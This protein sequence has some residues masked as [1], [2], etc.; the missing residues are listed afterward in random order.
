MGARPT[1]VLLPGH[2]CTEALWS[3]QCDALSDI[4]D[5]LPLPLLG[6]D[7]MQG[8][9][10]SVLDS[11]PARFSLA[12]LS[13][14]GH[15]AM[16]IMRLAPERVER[17]ALID[18]R[19]DVDSPERLKLRE[20]DR[21]RSLLELVPE[22]PARWMLPA[23]AADAGLA[24]H[25]ADMALTIG[26]ETRRRQQRALLARIDSRPSLRFVRCRTLILC[27]RQ[28]IPNPIWMHEE[29][30]GLIPDATLEIIERCG[31]LSPLEQP[32][33]V[34]ASLRRWLL[35]APTAVPG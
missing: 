35:A 34:T 12:A 22:L 4:A 15:V 6:A 17:L 30:A 21:D 29:M 7:S 31:H 8:L 26:E 27:G 1:L 16:E 10:E 5:C 11:A 32:E 9:A 20:V 19:A 3:A 2:L 24:A 23:H 14:G 33:A 28:D 18:T 13:M 25:V